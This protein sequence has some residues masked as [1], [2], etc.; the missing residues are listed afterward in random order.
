MIKLPVAVVL[1][2][3][4]N[5]TADTNTVA[6]PMITPDN[7]LRIAAVCAVLQTYILVIN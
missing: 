7:P 6:G 1:C 2:P 5:Q 3:I 4:G